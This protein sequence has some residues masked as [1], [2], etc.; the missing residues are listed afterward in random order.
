MMKSGSPITYFFTAYIMDVFYHIWAILCIILI[1][2]FFGLH[3]FGMYVPGLLWVFANPLF[4]YV[5]SYGLTRDRRLSNGVLLGII[6]T[7]SS[8]GLLVADLSLSYWS[9]SSSV[10][11]VL[12]ITSILFAWIPTI[13]LMFSMLAIS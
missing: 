11:T 2:D 10:H 7:C 3:F 13:D 9:S 8:L 12:L 6:I 5:F 1:P 4:L